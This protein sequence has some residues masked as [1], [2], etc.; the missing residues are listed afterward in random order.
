MRSSIGMDSSPKGSLMQILIPRF[1]LRF[2]R[3]ELSLI[4]LQNYPATAEGLIYANLTVMAK[5]TFK[6]T[7][8]YLLIVRRFKYN[9]SSVA[10]PCWIQNF[11]IFICCGFLFI[12]SAEE[13]FKEQNFSSCARWGYL[14]SFECNVVVCTDCMSHYFRLYEAYMLFVFSRPIQPYEGSYHI[15]PAASS[16]SF[17]SFLVW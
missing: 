6:W 3:K 8:P 5:P 7:L 12:L 9:P 2:Y 14:K 1:T 10:L 11:T 13:C 15:Q 17:R 16:A 4:I